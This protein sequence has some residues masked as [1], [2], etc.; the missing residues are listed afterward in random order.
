MNVTL[1]QLQALVEI[2][3]C[4][5]FTRAAERLHVAQPAVSQ[6]LR[7]LEDELGVRLVDRSTRKVELTEVGREFCGSVERV[8]ADL[9]QAIQ[10]TS[11]LVERKRGRITL[12]APPILVAALIPNV[13]S[14]FKRQFLGIDVVLVDVRI[15]QVVARVKS[16]EADIG[17]VS[18][19]E[20][21]NV[22]LPANDAGLV[23]RP[24]S[25]V[26]L[27]LF[28]ESQHPLASLRSPKW[29]DLKDHPIIALPSDSGIR[30]LLAHGYKSAGL[31][32]QPAY[33]VQQITTALAY[34]E[35]GLGITV[36]PAYAQASMS[37]RVTMRPLTP[38]VFR[39]DI[40]ITRRDR[41]LPPAAADFLR[42]L[43]RQ[44]KA[45]ESRY[46]QNN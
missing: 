45:L 16:G 7:E 27:M 23:N 20:I 1:R 2:A 42:V 22:A 11:D 26:K 29:H 33:E 38:G 34:V 46:A 3:A 31:A 41:S 39:D 18:G 19:V 17:I 8:M 9:R 24:L 15:D 35:A 36:L 43:Q 5:N 25:R 32:L 10:S 12:A 44:A 6:L 28:C 14:A 37:R 40:I 4:G 21:G 30:T 13:V